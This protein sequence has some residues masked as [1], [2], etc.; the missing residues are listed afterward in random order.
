MGGGENTA[1][2]CLLAP[3]STS[4]FLSEPGPTWVTGLLGQC[5]ALG[6]LFSQIQNYPQNSEKNLCAVG[7]QKL[8]QSLES[9]RVR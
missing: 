6:R 7:I 2:R 3:N 8:G 1:D 9:V 4:L 5:S